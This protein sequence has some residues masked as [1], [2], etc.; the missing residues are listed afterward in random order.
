MIITKIQYYFHPQ[1]V[2]WFVCGPQKK[3]NVTFIP[4]LCRPAEEK[5]EVTSEV[6]M[7]RKNI[8]WSLHFHF[9]QFGQ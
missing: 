3:H 4:Y 6:I 8:I 1:F 9:K 7:L 5:A 2:M